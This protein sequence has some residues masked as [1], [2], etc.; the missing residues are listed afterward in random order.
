MFRDPNMKP[1]HWYLIMCQKNVLVE[2]H[3]S[4]LRRPCWS[5][6]KV[7][8]TFTAACSFQGRKQGWILIHNWSR[9]RNEKKMSITSSP[10]T[11]W[12]FKNACFVQPT[13]RSLKYFDIK[14]RKATI[15]PIWE[16][17]ARRCFTFWIKKLFHKQIQ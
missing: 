2:I 7:C 13:V 9:K 16:D 1:C 12:H 15:L 11:R 6:L 5:L 8:A 4:I 3:R 17:R 10:S 14:Q